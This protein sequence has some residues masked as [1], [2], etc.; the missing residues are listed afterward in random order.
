MWF[1]L[2][3]LIRQNAVVEIP[4]LLLAVH[5]MVVPC[6]EGGHDRGIHRAHVSQ[7]LVGLQAFDGHSSA[8]E[9]SLA[10]IVP[11]AAAHDQHWCHTGECVAHRKCA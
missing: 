1:E 5:L 3:W 10:P 2:N 7:D 4:L 8:A 6:S 11:V 9:A